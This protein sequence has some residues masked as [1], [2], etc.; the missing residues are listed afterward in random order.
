VY[1][2]TLISSEVNP[3]PPEHKERSFMFG[4]FLCE[5]S[6]ARFAPLIHPTKDPSSLDPRQFCCGVLV[7]YYHTGCGVLIYYYHQ[8]VCELITTI[9]A[10]RCG[11]YSVLGPFS[12]EKALCPT[13][14]CVPVCTGTRHASGT[15]LNPYSIR[16]TPNVYHVYHV[17]RLIS[18]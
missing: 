8:R 11:L 13:G 1:G 10:Q 7:Y 5:P 6:Q 9:I 14:P 12:L 17:Y 16:L 4:H 3:Q 15:R 2:Y 18:L